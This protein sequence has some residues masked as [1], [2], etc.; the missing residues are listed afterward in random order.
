MGW[1]IMTIAMMLPTT[2]PVIALFDTLAGERRDHALLVTLVIA[3]YLAIWAAFGIAVYSGHA[4][5]AGL[6]DMTA[7]S[8]DRPWLGGPAVLFIAGAYQFTSL[9]YRCLEKCRSP[10]S[11]VIQHWQG[12][13]DRWQA[14]RLGIDHG[15]FCVGCCWTLM[16][17]MFVTGLGN[18]AWMFALAAV[19][20]IE[21][22][23]SWGRRI[24]TPLGIVL[25]VC[26]LLAAIGR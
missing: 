17:L 15:L 20:A 9:K 1:T 12:R 21:K 18:L 19:M 6:F 10:L 2:F 25:V 16:L 26:G 5:L 13:R 4:L 3:G 11:F 8:A 7:R 22:N 14:F 23:V 24:S